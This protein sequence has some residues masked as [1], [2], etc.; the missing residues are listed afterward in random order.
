MITHCSCKNPTLEVF[1]FLV[2]VDDILITGNDR[3]GIQKLKDALQDSFQMKDLGLAQYFLGLK[4]LVIHMG[5][6]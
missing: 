6:F 1:L 3:H 5:I 4:Y 2:Y